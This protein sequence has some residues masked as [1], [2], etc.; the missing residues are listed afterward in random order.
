MIPSWEQPVVGNLSDK[1][2][3]FW[4]L[5]IGS[6]AS[7]RSLG[8]GWEPGSQKSSLGALKL[9]K[10]VVACTPRTRPCACPPTITTYY[11]PSLRLVQ[12]SHACGIVATSKQVAVRIG[13]IACIAT[14]H[15]ECSTVPYR[16]QYCTYWENW[17]SSWLPI[18]MCYSV[19][20]ESWEPADA[21]MHRGGGAAPRGRSGAG[22]GRAA[23]GRGRG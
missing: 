20:W 8:I 21:R 15:D 23:G 4:E 14:V 19:S 18:L 9:P 7:A 2:G 13:G 6:D 17:E 16:T 11:P 5:V 10:A 1:L 12:R 22:D 3:A